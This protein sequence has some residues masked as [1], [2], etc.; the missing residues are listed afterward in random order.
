MPE[1]ILIVGCPGAGKSTL[2]RRL[3]TLTGL[4]VYHLDLLWH[5][6]DRTTVDIETFARSLDQI[7][8]RDQ[9]IIDGNYGRTLP[10]RLARCDEVFFLDYPLEICLEGARAR[11][12]HQRADLPWLEETL[13]PE[14][15]QWILDYPKERLPRL[16]ARLASYEGAFPIHTFH[17]H[18]EA[19]AYLAALARS[20]SEQN[21]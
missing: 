9:W 19:D 15:Y 8:A 13:D 3:G 12:G 6:P 18:S 14:F 17:T 2:A 5:R 16:R 10:Q 4:P 1:R 11:V 7:L 21:S 20:G